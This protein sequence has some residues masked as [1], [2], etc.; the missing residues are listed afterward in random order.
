M[1]FSLSKED[2][3]AMATRMAEYTAKVPEPLN[4]KFTEKNSREEAIA[5]WNARKVM[6][7]DLFPPCKFCHYSY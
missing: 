3:E 1:L 4:R 6:Q 5:K 2:I 7:T